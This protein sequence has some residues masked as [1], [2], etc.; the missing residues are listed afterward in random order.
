MTEIMYDQKLFILW[1]VVSL[2]PSS[3]LVILEQEAL[4]VSI[5]ELIK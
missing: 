1:T 4:G 5:E 2:Y 3:D